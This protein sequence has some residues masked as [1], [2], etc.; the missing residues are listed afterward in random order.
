MAIYESGEDYLET[1]LI[2]HNT[3]GFVRSIDVANKLGYSK[4]SISRA[5]S[6]LKENGYITVEKSGELVLTDLGKEKAEGI[7]LRHLVIKDFLV[8][9]LGVN[10]D[11]AN[12]DACKIEHDIS[13]ESFTKLK[14]FLEEHQNKA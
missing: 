7:Y 14:A 12:A 6:I 10:E 9:V 5:I 11:T 8:S 3:T 2:L 1:I 4:P 13:E